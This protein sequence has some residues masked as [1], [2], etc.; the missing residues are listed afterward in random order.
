MQGVFYY[1][2]TKALNIDIVNMLQKQLLL[3]LPLA[4]F[5]SLA[6]ALYILSRTKM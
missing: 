5:C 4:F 1:L 6:V 2:H 3:K